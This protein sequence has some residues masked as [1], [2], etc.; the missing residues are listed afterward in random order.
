MDGLEPVGM[1]FEERLIILRE[2]GQRDCNI[3]RVAH[4][5]VKNALRLL[6][7]RKLRRL[8][9]FR[10]A[11]THRIHSDGMMTFGPDSTAQR[12]PSRPDTSIAFSR[13]SS[14]SRNA[15]SSSIS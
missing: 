7:A 12:K 15:S 13:P 6:L 11:P 5:Q 2:L 14:E 1:R 4:Q 3:V 10:R 8:L 9:A